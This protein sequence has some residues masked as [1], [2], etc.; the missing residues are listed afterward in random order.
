MNQSRINSLVARHRSLDRRI[1]EEECR[2]CPDAIM[3]AHMKRQRLYLKDN[4]V[5]ASQH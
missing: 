3:L 4:L 2:P 1:H 5:L